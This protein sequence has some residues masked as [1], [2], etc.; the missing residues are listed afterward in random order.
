MLAVSVIAG[1]GCQLLGR[2]LTARTRPM[3]HSFILIRFGIGSYARKSTPR[4]PRPRLCR[5][6]RPRRSFTG[7]PRMSKLLLSKL[8]GEQQWPLSRHGCWDCNEQRP[9]KAHRVVGEC[10]LLNFFL[11]LRGSATSTRGE[12]RRA[13]TSTSPSVLVAP[14]AAVQTARCAFE[15]RGSLL[16]TASHCANAE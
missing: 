12:C 10:K 2:S 15:C 1:A 3:C 14:A 7:R 8:R 11:L 13:R 9:R 5:Y 16:L 6:G 4:Q